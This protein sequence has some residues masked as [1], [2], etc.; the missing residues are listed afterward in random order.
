M[1]YAVANGTRI[2]NEGEKEF[3]GVTEEGVMRNVK[4]QICA[5]TTSLLSVKRIV[6]SGHRVVF[7]EE[8]YVED[9]STGER[10][11]LEE[12]DGMYMVKF[13]VKNESF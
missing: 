1:E 12:R 13:W 3:V 8:S 11:N 9:R 10:M 4:A 6:G 5:V 2:P 7:D